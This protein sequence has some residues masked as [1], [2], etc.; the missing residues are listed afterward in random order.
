MK[1]GVILINVRDWDDWIGGLSEDDSNG[2][3]VYTGNGVVDIDKATLSRGEVYNQ[4][5]RDVDWL[6]MDSGVVDWIPVLISSGKKWRGYEWL[7]GIRVV[8][9]GERKISWYLWLDQMWRKLISVDGK[10]V[11]T[12]ATNDEYIETE[13]V[14]VYVQREGNLRV[15]EELKTICRSKME[16]YARWEVDNAYKL[17][18]DVVRRNVNT[19]EDD[20]DGKCMMNEHGLYRML[21]WVMR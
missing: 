21:A 12:P 14:S 6:Y 13:G 2:L 19:D 16:S 3:K 4:Y 7:P 10:F 5:R 15:P 9:R 1:E 17:Y 18:R 11:Y 8:L 20:S